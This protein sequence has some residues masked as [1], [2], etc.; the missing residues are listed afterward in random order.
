M[1][2]LTHVAYCEGFLTSVLDLAHCRTQGIH[3]NSGRDILYRT[4]P[5]NVLANLEYNGSYWLI[6]AD[7]TRRPLTLPLILHAYSTAFRSSHAP[8]LDHRIDQQI[9]HQIWA[10]PSRKAIEHLEAHTN[11]V[12][13]TGDPIPD[14]PCTVCIESRLTKIVSRRSSANKATRPFYH[15]AIDLV[16]IVPMSK[17]CWN[18]NRY[19]LHAVNEFSKWHELITTPCKDKPML[20]RWFMNLVRK[21]QCMYNYDVVFV[22]TDGE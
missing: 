19:A 15:I 12:S 5:Y 22:H 11:S 6:D 8:K 1:L 9:A 20:V 18:G 14:C 2:L 7:P 21:I 10:H 13:V 3:F 16:Y 4:A 17:R